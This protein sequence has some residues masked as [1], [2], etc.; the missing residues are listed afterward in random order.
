MCSRDDVSCDVSFIHCTHIQNKSILQKHFLEHT[1]SYEWLKLLLITKTY[2]GI[3]LETKRGRGLVPKTKQKPVQQ[4]LR[5]V[6]HNG[7]FDHLFTDPK[8]GVGLSHYAA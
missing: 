6:R 4:Q 1:R 8:L 2:S 3:V 7:S 5:S